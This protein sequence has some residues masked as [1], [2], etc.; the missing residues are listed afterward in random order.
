MDPVSL[1]IGYWLFSGNTNDQDTMKPAFEKT[2]KNLNI[3]R[4]IVIA[5]GGLNAGKNLAYILSKGNGYIVSKSVR[6]CSKTEK[7]W[8]LDDGGYTNVN[9][10][11]KYK[12]KIREREIVDEEGKK[13]KVTEKIIVYWSKNHYEEELKANEKFVEY[14]NSVLADP[15]K[16]KNATKKVSKFFKKAEKEDENNGE[17][18]ENSVK[19]EITTLDI[20]K[21]NEFLKLF[22]YYFLITS[23]IEMDA[24]E[25]I[26]K[27]RGLSRIEDSFRIIKTDLE[28]RP[29]YVD[30]PEHINAHFLI[31]F[32]S[33]TIIRAIQVRV[34]EY[35]GLPT[36]SF[37][38][39]TSG[40]TANNIINALLDMD[41]IILPNNTVQFKKPSAD[42]SELLEAFDIKIDYG[43]P[44]LKK[45]KQLKAS[46]IRAGIFRQK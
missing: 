39:W 26:R 37:T 27:Y 16:L 45:L 1:P 40:M 23:E 30:T 18:N 44:S 35:H 25:V 15:S 22:G 19:S 28:G 31:C 29:V 6:K 36:S 9:D 7:Q 43:F 3:G 4:V 10:D 21:I 32:I 8:L 20:D 17:V 38:K 5:D 13:K 11:F 41:V 33:L 24:L 12:E 14:L 34:L 46:F 2:V 42:L